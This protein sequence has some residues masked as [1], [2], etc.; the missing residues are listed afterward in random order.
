MKDKLKK[1]ML[2]AWRKHHANSLPSENFEQ[3]FMAGADASK[4][5]NW[6][7]ARKVRPNHMQICYCYDKFMGGGRVYVYDDMSKYWCTQSTI[8]HD[9]NGDNHVCDYADFRVTHWI[10]NYDG[11]PLTANETY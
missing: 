7:D 10:P 4:D 1:A 11:K 6:F 3:G 5:L 8:E 2:R 9:P